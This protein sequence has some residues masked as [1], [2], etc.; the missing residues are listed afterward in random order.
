MAHGSTA[1]P[2]PDPSTPLI[3]PK[4]EKSVSFA[5]TAY[6]LVIGVI[7]GLDG[8]AFFSLGYWSTCVMALEEFLETTPLG[9][10]DASYAVIHPRLPILMTHVFKLARI[11]VENAPAVG[12]DFL[13]SVTNARVV[14]ATASAGAIVAASAVGK[15]FLLS[16]TNARVVFATASAGAIVASALRIGALS[17]QQFVVDMVV[18]W[19]VCCYITVTMGRYINRVIGGV[20]GDC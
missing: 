16:V 9:P 1:E 5:S 7:V 13:L 17:V 8:F 6:F 20:I 2:A 11:G 14:F 3:V 19:V 4:E 18:L 15:E 10:L 12:K